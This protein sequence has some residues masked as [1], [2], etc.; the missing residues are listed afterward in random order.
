MHDW[1]RARIL[2]GAGLLVAATAVTTLPTAAVAG[3]GV[4]GPPAEEHCVLVVAGQA[5][6]GEL[7]TE[8]LVCSASRPAA[9]RRAEEGTALAAD[10]AIGVHYDGA[11]F[12]GS[13]VTVVGSS[14]I[15]GWLNLPAAWNDR[16]SSTAN[17]CPQIRH[18]LHVNL[19]G[20]SAS[21]F[22]PGGN[23]GALSNE[24]SSIQ[25]LP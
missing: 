9:L 23:L 21:T 2:L 16:I 6:D 11:G 13:S 20:T 19:A 14:C 10:F 24:A 1:E 18:F 7:L 12:T 22:S 8:P 25:Y 3:A 15:G 5:P 17:G 4:A